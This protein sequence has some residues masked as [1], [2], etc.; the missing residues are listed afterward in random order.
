MAEAHPLGVGST[1]TRSFVTDAQ[2]TIWQD[3][4]GA[5][6]AAVPAAAGGT[7]SAIQ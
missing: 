6:F 7:I 3:T 4:T 1:G 5:T 2:G